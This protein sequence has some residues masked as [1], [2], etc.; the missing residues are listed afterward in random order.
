MQS[1]SFLLIFYGALF[2]LAVA[3][4]AKTWKKLLNES[5]WEYTAWSGGLFLIAAFN[6]F[7]MQ[8]RMEHLG[9]SFL[10]YFF[11]MIPPLLFYLLVS[12]FTPEK[13]ENVKDHF[14]LNRKKIFSILLLF[15]L[16]NMLISYFTGDRGIQVNILRGIAAILAVACVLSEKMI[17][18]LLLLIYAV[19]GIFTIAFFQL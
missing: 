5:Y 2:A 3:E 1:N 12:V 10:Y 14:L 7:G 9:V 4:L 15:V 18:R 19:G 13:D 8:Y 11:M 17:Y 6:W 16:S